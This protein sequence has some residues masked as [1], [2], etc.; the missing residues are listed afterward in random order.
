MKTVNARGK[1]SVR[2]P[3][4]S[5][6]RQRASYEVLVN[7]AYRFDVWL[8]DDD[9]YEL[10]SGHLT[11]G[12]SEYTPSLGLSEYLAS[13]IW[14]GE[15]PLEPVEENTV[16]VNS[17]VPSPD[18]ILPEP[19][20]PHGVE[21]SPGDMERTARNGEFSGRHTTE[22]IQWAYS[23]D[24]SPLRVKGATAHRVGDRVVVFS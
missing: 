16:V 1:V 5:K 6:D 8:A 17:A 13:V 18:S 7:P 14:L 2:Y 10:L 4:P 12:R 24:D 23:R 21:R 11:D 19:G 9:A 22:F 20:S 3:D 15:S